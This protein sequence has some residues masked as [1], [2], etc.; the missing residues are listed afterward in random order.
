ML[1]QKVD[2]LPHV[3][4]YFSHRTNDAESRYHSYELETLAV[5]RA[6]EHFRHYLY[7][8]RF[9]VFTDCN[10]LKASHSKKDLTPRVH[11]W[12]AILQSYD[13]DVVY[14]EGKNM[15]HADFLSR[16][17]A[18]E[19][20]SPKFKQV[21]KIVNFSELER[22]WLLVEQKRDSEI[23]DIVSKL[24]TNDFP[25]E[26][27]HTYDVRLCILYRKVERGKNSKWLPMIPRSLTWTLIGH[28]HNEIKHLGYEKYSISYMTLLVSQYDKICKKICRFLCNL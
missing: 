19:N 20:Q 12:W 25:I 23:K 10:S 26:I 4:A 28:V 18:L 7:G 8:C 17:F 11:R 27:S 6:V 2:S 3:V 14:K 16:N 24:K 1:I 15:A 21:P 5:V 22:V 9:T 13:F